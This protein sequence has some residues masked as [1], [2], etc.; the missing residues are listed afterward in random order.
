MEMTPIQPLGV[1]DNIMVIDLDTGTVLG[2]NLV[3]AYVAYPSIDDVLNSDSS[4]IEYG[5]RHGHPLFVDMAD[6]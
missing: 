5:K 1:S 3:L 2:T 6:A 4:A